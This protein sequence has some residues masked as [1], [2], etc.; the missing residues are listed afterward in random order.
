MKNLWKKLSTGITGM[1]ILY[2]ITAFMFFT[3]YYNWQYAKT[4][5]FMKWLLFGEVV[6][7][8]KAVAWPYFMFVKSGGTV[9]HVGK[10]I[11]YANKATAIINKGGPYQQISQADMEEIIGYYKKALAE[12]KEA[13]IE[14]MN[15]HYPGF[16][17]HFRSE[18]MKGLE[19]F[20]QSYEKGDMVASIASQA[21]LDQWGN[22]YQANI[23]G[24]R[25]R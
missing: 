12:A 10:A 14:S 11:D 16:G 7:T 2:F 18:F 6:A 21:L 3:P 9:S 5:G 19:L 23:G 4:H 22:W 13:D 8:A 20:L 15:K 25:G 24:I 1:L 17:D